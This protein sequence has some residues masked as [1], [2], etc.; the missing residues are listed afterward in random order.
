MFNELENLN[1]NKIN[2]VKFNRKKLKK[3]IKIKYCISKD[4][5][6]LFYVHRVKQI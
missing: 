2:Y 5:Y 4:N 1:S 6:K 3:C